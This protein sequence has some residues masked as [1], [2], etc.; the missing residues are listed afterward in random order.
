MGVVKK[1]G[2]ENYISLVKKASRS[3]KNYIS[4]QIKFM[5]A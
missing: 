4:C 5:H 3:C 2:R 1:K